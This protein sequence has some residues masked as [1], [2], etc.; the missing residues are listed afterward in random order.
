MTWLCM[1]AS[2]VQQ[3]LRFHL[4]LTSPTT[5]E[6]TVAETCLGRFSWMGVTILE[7]MTTYKRITMAMVFNQ[8]AGTSRVWIWA[9]TPWWCYSGDQCIN[10]ILNY[11]PDRSRDLSFKFN[12]LRIRL[13]WN[14]SKWYCVHIVPTHGWYQPYMVKLSIHNWP[15]S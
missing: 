11:S 13:A 7:E 15:F 14:I 8:P 2:S 10:K 5:S 9:I 3:L 1:P 4:H 12:C 6:N